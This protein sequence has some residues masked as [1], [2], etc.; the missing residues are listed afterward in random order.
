MLSSFPPAQPAP[1]MHRLHLSVFSYH[2]IHPAVLRKPAFL[3][4]PLIILSLLP[5]PSHP[6]IILSPPPRHPP[7]YV[8]ATLCMLI[9]SAL[10]QL[11]Q[12]KQM[13]KNKQWAKTRN[14]IISP[15]MIHYRP[16]IQ[17]LKK[18]RH[19][20]NLNSELVLFIFRFLVFQLVGAKY[21]HFKTKL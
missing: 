4:Y 5:L 8:C 13:H 11:G 6:P 15:T 9:R 20:S 2:W 17:P 16:V 18:E 3:S 19:N 21:Q 1:Y 10:D 14:K 12:A 7:Y